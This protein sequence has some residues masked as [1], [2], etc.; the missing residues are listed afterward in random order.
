MSKRKGV[1]SSIN[2]WKNYSSLQ[3]GT[4]EAENW[5]R[6]TIPV[7]PTLGDWLG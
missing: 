7:D 4:W 2:T 6:Q 1:T 5:S 3:P